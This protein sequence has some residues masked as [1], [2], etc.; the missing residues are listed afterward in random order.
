MGG[1]TETKT[2]NI[3]GSGI[4][5]DNEIRFLH[6]LGYRVWLSKPIGLNMKDK[7]EIEYNG[8]RIV[9]NQ[10]H[11]LLDNMESFGFKVDRAYVVV[12]EFDEPSLPT[13][14]QW[15]W[16]P[17]DA[18]HAIDLSR[19]AKK[20][21]NFKKWPT[22]VAHEYN[23]L[24]AYKRHIALVYITIREVVELLKSAGDG[25][26]DD[27]DIIRQ[28]LNKLYQLQQVIHEGGQRD[29]DH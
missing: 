21:F 20:F 9:Q 26:E 1:T 14:Q 11:N 16:S 19:W 12:D 2:E 28:A 4:G 18:M 5:F 24:L 7:T 10:Y 8:E 6:P 25:L 29:S 15:F 13:V 27:S 22:T 17:I 3:L 23:N